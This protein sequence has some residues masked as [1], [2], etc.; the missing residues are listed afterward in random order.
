MPT[1]GSKACARAVAL[2]ALALTLAAP[3]W[4][5]PRPEGPLVSDVVI[6]GGGQ[7]PLEQIRG[8]LKTRPG[9]PYVAE[10]LQEDVRT[11]YATRQFATVSAAH[12]PDGPN[13]VK[14]LITLR[15]LPSV[16]RKVEYRG[17]H[18]LSRDDLDAV[19]G[20]RAG[21][22][23]NPVFTRTAC[24]RIVTRY[25]EDG[26]PF[27]ACDLLD[28]GKLGDT[29]VIFH[30]TEGPKVKVKD[31]AFTGNDFVSSSVLKTH[32]R[33]SNGI[34]G[35]GVLGGDY[36]PALV[37]ADINELLKYYRSYGFHDVR[38]ERELRY[39]G[40][41]HDLTVVFHIREGVRYRVK[42]APPV[43][44]VGP[45]LRPKLEAPSKLR[46]GDYYDQRKVDAD[47]ARI[48]DYLGYMGHD[49]RVKAVPVYSRATPGVVSVLY[50]VE[51]AR[52]AAPAVPEAR[53]AEAPAPPGRG[54]AGALSAP[55]R[56]G[57]RAS[58]GCC[59]CLASAC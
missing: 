9:K 45:K 52:P 24:Q 3:A 32:I 27:A 31:I 50:E 4:G 39:S 44:G 47:L 1:P 59:P 58:P 51:H 26:R 55:R 7:V 20:L 57:A 23:L 38:V 19:T 25:N 13:R 41:G 42:E 10:V 36:N 56:G 15:D 40:D 5:E 2:L 33:T 43:T 12:V 46:P 16:I 28:G 6:R 29:D 35:L 48:K 49:V 11:L 30:I 17:A 14:V 34:L 21:M 53:A 54:G 18:A 37:D 8:H 22:P